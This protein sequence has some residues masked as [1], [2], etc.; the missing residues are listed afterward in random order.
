MA[1][2]AHEI[3]RMI[4]A[5]LPDAAVEH[6]QGQSGTLQTG[7]GRVDAVIGVGRRLR[8]LGHGHRRRRCIEIGECGACCEE[9]QAGRDEDGD[10]T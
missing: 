4:K 1:M 9:D 10:N 5:A 6:R 2:D 7:A 3:E 8:G